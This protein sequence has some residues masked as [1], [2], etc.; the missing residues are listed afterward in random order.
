MGQRARTIAKREMITTV[1]TNA[2][3]MAKRYACHSGKA[4]TVLS[5]FARQDVTQNMDIV[6]L[7]VNAGKIEWFLIESYL[8]LSD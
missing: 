6:R 2:H 7:L 8:R 1:T 5:R 3:K 4:H